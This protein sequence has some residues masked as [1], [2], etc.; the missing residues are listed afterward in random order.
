MSES[1]RGFT[2]MTS[3]GMFSKKNPYELA[4]IVEGTSEKI[5]Y[6][7]YDGMYKGY[8]HE[9]TFIMVSFCHY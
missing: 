8:D 7:L 9:G 6:V 1:H 4:C 5:R 2:S 3:S